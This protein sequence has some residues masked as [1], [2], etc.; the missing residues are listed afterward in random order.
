MFGR[1]QVHEELTVI[2]SQRETNSL[3]SSLASCQASNL[4]FQNSACC[5]GFRNER[6]GNFLAHACPTTPS[7]NF[8]RRP[9]R[10]KKHINFKELSHEE[11]LE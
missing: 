6:I 1:S 8:N 4:Y 3:H 2:K 7:T 10:Q 9:T 5:P 11:Y